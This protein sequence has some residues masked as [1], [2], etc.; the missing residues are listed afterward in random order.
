MA[1]GQHHIIDTGNGFMTKSVGSG[2]SFWRRIQGQLILVLLVSLVPT[3]IIQAHLFSEWYKT[4]RESEL[5][6][7]LQIARAVAKTFDTFIQYE[8]HQEYAMGLALTGLKIEDQ[9]RYIEENIA[10][11]TLFSNLMW[12]S[13]EGRIL[14]SHLPG[15]EGRSLADR[16]Y[17]REIIEGRDWAVSDL[18]AGKANGDPIVA[19]ARA[20][21]DK[22]DHILGIVVTTILSDNLGE[23]LAIDRPHGGGHALVDSTGTLVYRYPWINPTM[24]QRDWIKD[25]PEFKEA[26]NGK[27]VSKT[28]FAPFEGKNRLVGFTPVSSIGWAASAGCTEKIAME[29]VVSQLVPQALLLFAV[30]VAAFGAALLCSRFIVSSVE[31]LRRHAIALGSADTPDPLASSGPAEIGELTD[32]FNEMAERLRSR[33]KSLLDQ[34]EWLR[35]TLS[36]IGDAVLATDTAGN[37]AFLNPVAANLTGWQNGEAVG[38]PAEEIFRIVNEKTHEPADDIIGRVLR[39]GCTIALANH[40]ALVTRDGEEVPIEDSA[41]PIRDAEGKVS[42]AVL[43]FHDV[44]QRRRAQEALRESEARFRLMANSIPQLAWIARADGH[45]YWYNQQWYAYTGTTPEQMEGWG[46]QSVHDPEVLPKVL[47]EW[48]ASIATGKPF[49]M[50]FPLQGADGSFRQFLTRVLPMKD[51][52]G[53]IVQWFGTNTDITERKLLEEELSKSRDELE[54]RVRERT[55]ELEKL[56]ED[57]VREIEERKRAEARLSATM[58]KLERSNQA[59]QDFASIASHDLQEPLRKVETFGNMLKEKC[60]DSLGEQCGGYLDRML[61]AGKRMQTL[62]AALLEYSRL[63][64]RANPFKEVDLT[65][66]VKEVLSDLEVRIET[67]GGEVRFGE[68]PVIEADPVQMRQ[69]FQNLIGNALKFHK[70]GERPVITVSHSSADNGHLLIRVEDNGIGFD[71]RYIERIFA[72]FHRLHGR[73]SPYEGTGMGLAICRKIVERHGGSITAGSTPGIGTSFI[74]QLPQKQSS[75]A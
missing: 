38:R 72:P 30:T 18:I 19:I 36:S 9:K 52:E 59:L 41:A 20:I 14:V 12:V 37:V 55:A 22:Q 61:D 23:V 53:R 16:K 10:E 48:K 46:W 56:N 15:L 62:I 47:E 33:E 69:L 57:L 49:D 4:R 1:F 63:T 7:N 45:I 70:E 71:E 40:T 54:L 26:L 2:Q 39:E 75:G 27:E 11:Y 29:S 31:R 44:T 60:G 50:V 43:V 25:Y 21:R 17:F 13:P 24:Q 3:L 5:Q 65:K 35:V 42:G 64:T 74:V 6:A 67:T 51:S 28:V 68:L 32:A 58:A 8:L 66:I 73:S 34:R